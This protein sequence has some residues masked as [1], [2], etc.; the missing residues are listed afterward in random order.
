MNRK[1]SWDS[2][3]LDVINQVYSKAEQSEAAWKFL[4]DMEDG[5]LT[6]ARNGCAMIRIRGEQL[7]PE[8]YDTLSATSKEA[9]I[10]ALGNAG[11]VSFKA[12]EGNTKIVAVLSPQ[13]R[14]VLNCMTFSLLNRLEKLD[15]VLPARQEKI[16]LEIQA[17]A[18]TKQ[19][20]VAVEMLIAMLYPWAQVQ[21]VIQG[22]P[23]PTYQ[24]SDPK[25][26]PKETPQ[27]R[28]PKDAKGS[29]VPKAIVAVV[30]LLILVGIVLIVSQIKNRMEADQPQNPPQAD[31][32]QQATLPPETQA[33]ECS[34]VWQDATCTEA[35]VCTL[36]GETDGEALG[37]TWRDA[38]RTEPKTCETCG[39]TEG[40]PL[41]APDISVS[42]RISWIAD[43][44][45]DVIT[46]VNG[47]L[48]NVREG[49][50]G[51]YYYSDSSGET[52]FVVAAKGIDGLGEYSGSYR[53]YY[54]FHDG[55]LI[56]AYLEGNDTHRLYFY[57]GE[58]MRWRYQAPGQGK[59]DA[60][61][62]DFTY[63]EDFLKWES[64]VLGEVA[65]FF[66]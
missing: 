15:A 59:A 54:T 3:R 44:Y 4:T 5:A 16:A 56:F 10:A 27:K 50:K 35:A 28:N 49:S 52:H 8:Q 6:E 34:H 32:S 39:E 57:E 29:W 53:R 2:G 17:P 55:E 61:I 13:V 25:R 33:P 64:L 38:T 11:I 12:M 19:G 47:N 26:V 22:A 21:T 66:E 60:H 7:T 46:K 58:L 31:A 20:M 9:V 62:E 24:Y 14:K 36:C 51:V 37:H 1:I 41:G 63:S 40:E 23:A 42:S 48:Y 30:A 65:S 18:G 43:R 45:D